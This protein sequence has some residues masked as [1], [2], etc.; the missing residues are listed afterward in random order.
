MSQ[1]GNAYGVHLTGGVWGLIAPGLFTSQKNYAVL[2]GSAFSA[3]DLGGTANKGR[4]FTEYEATTRT[5]DLT[6]TSRSEFCAGV[7]YGGTGSQLGANVIFG[8]ALL[9]WGLVPMYVAVKVLMAM[10]PDDFSDGSIN[11]VTEKEEKELLRAMKRMPNSTWYEKV[12][13]RERQK[14]S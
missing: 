11:K 12:F 8:L 14:G 4:F 10:F 3:S 6:F 13:S 7:F 1:R 5:I 9:V 2:M